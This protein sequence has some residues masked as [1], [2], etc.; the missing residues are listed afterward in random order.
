MTSHFSTAN[1]FAIRLALAICC[2]SLYANGQSSGSRPLFVR[3]VPTISVTPSRSGASFTRIALQ[4][5]GFA[6]SN[7]TAKELLKFAY[8]T[9]PYALVSAPDW[10]ATAK[11]DLQVI[12]AQADTSSLSPDALREH[13]KLLVRTVLAEAFHLRFHTV[14]TFVSGYSLI[15]DS[16]GVRIAAHDPL[17]WSTGRMLNSNGEIDMTA[18]AI[19]SLADELS[20]TMGLPVVDR[21][22]LIG[23]YD[24][25]LS[26]DKNRTAGDESFKYSGLTSALRAQLGLELVPEQQNVDKFVIDNIAAPAN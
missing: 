12:E 11:F 18:L 2:F 13:R 8:G 17:T 20:D 5:T 23:I 22:G 6:A 14:N 10:L 24:V 7:I 21:T 15:Q 4:A 26:W 9:R 19:G 25:S 16:S 1:R 3:E